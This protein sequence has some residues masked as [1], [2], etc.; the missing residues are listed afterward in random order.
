MGYDHI[1][2]ASMT[3]DFKVENIIL[4]SCWQRGHHVAE[5]ILKAAKIMSPFEW[6]EH[7]G[8]YDILCLFG[9]NKMILVDGLLA[10]EREETDEEHGDSIDALLQKPAWTLS[11]P[12]VLDTVPDSLSK[13]DG[14]DIDDLSGEL[15][16]DASNLVGTNTAWVST[17]SDAHSKKVHKASILQ[18]FSS[19]LSASN[20]KNRLKRVRGY[21]KYNEMTNCTTVLAPDPDNPVEVRVKD[22]AL[23]LVRCCGAVFLGLFQVL[24]V[25]SC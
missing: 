20:S 23:V 16:L 9:N 15:D 19:G 2:P 3:G 25:R 13:D 1:N 8:D 17:D 6:M 7:S 18:I 5:E 4:Q 14:P 21:S 12:S 22:P 11:N 10:G 24:S